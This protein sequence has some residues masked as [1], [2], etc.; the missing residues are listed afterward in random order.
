M[1]L[2]FNL[3]CISRCL[4]TGIAVSLVGHATLASAADIRWSP[5]D[6]FEHASTIAPGKTEEVCG[7]IEPRLPVEWRFAASGPLSFNIHRH[8]GS[9]VIYSVKSYLTREQNGSLS[10]TFNHEWCWMWQNE[11]AEPVTVKLDLKR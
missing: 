6:T 9:E 8:S 5:S 7:R 4:G 10:P 3:R 2:R 1:N 11:S